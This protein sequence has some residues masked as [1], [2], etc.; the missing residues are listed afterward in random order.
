ME[1]IDRKSGSALWHQ[2]GEI[3]AAD[4]AAGT[5]APGEKLPTE[6]ELMQRFGVS[7]FT[8]RQALGH[9]EQ[10]GLVRA[11]QGRGTFVHKG[12][13]DYTLS[14]RTRFHKNLIEQGFE[15]GGEL[16]VHEIVPATERVATY[17]K[18]A[19]GAPVIHRRGLMTADG[20]P[21]ELGDSY[22]PAGR[23][24]DFD[25]ARSQYETISAALASYGVTDYER[26]STEI[27]ARMPTVEEARLLRQP[28]SVPL[29]IIRKVDADAEG[30][31]ITYSE[32]IWSAER[33]TFNV[34]LR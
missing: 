24:P 3:L 23:F 25:K 29:L 4:I 16:L 12:V 18:L 30:L 33:I 17:L 21:V 11:E 2:I 19:M 8:V 27:E 31:P 14:K 15:P 13:L 10:R 34:D 32:S 9:L 1:T 5:F 28:K 6:P 26:L 7:R 22:Y 20:I